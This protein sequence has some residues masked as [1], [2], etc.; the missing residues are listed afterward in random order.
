VKLVGAVGGGAINDLLDFPHSGFSFGRR[1]AYAPLGIPATFDCILKVSYIRSS[2]VD[3]VVELLDSVTAVHRKNL[4]GS[5][6]CAG[7]T[8][9]DYDTGDLFRLADAADGSRGFH[10]LL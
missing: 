7:G 4:S 5:E 8:K 9:P 10:H 2:A 1:R 6:R 3:P